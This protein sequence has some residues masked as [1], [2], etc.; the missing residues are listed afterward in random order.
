MTH[1]EAFAFTD[2]NQLANLTLPRQATFI[3]E[4]AFAYCESLTEEIRLNRETH[5]GSEA[6]HG[7]ECEVIVG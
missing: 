5:L 4:R 2:C 3:G 1:I 6:F 7:C